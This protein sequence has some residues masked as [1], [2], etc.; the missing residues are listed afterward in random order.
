M[1]RDAGLTIDRAEGVGFFWSIWWV[2]RMASGSDHCPD[3]STP[4]PRIIRNWEETWEAFYKTAAGPRVVEMLDTMI[5]KSVRI[6]AR[7][8]Y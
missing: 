2:L 3:F 5:P 1:I 4:P 7:K 6:V 8:P